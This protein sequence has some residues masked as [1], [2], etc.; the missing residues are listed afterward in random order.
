MEVCCCSLGFIPRVIDCV[1]DYQGDQVLMQMDLKALD[2]PDFD[3]FKKNEA[4][5]VCDFRFCCM[6]ADIS[7][8]KG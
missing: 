3:Q 2:D 1:G 6:F 7:S 4:I 8:K 5:I